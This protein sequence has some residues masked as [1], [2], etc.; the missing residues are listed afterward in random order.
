MFSFEPQ[1]PSP[2]FLEFCISPFPEDNHS[3]SLSE[4]L[5]EQFA[6][7]KLSDYQP[8]EKGAPETYTSVEKAPQLVESTDS[9]VT[10]FLTPTRCGEK[11]NSLDHDLFEELFIDQEQLYDDIRRHVTSP[12]E[13]RIAKAVKKPKLKF[14]EAKPKKENSKLVTRMAYFVLEQIKQS[15]LAGTTEADLEASI[16]DWLPEKTKEKLETNRHYITRNLRVILKILNELEVIHTDHSDRIRHQWTALPGYADVQSKTHEFAIKTKQIQE[17]KARLENIKQV[18]QKLSFL[19]KQ[20]K[21]QSAIRV[22]KCDPPSDG[23]MLLRQNEQKNT[24]EVGVTSIIR[25]R[26]QTTSVLDKLVENDFN[27]EL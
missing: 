6:I 16:F 26:T 5:N 23:L 7:E 12:A 13:V 18:H 22:N 14:R 15:G 9:W 3:E 1:S 10:D 11:M 17:K 19:M 24:P 27:L 2:A 21:Q 4:T 20:N 8:I 25:V